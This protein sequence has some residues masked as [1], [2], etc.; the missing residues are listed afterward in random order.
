M[1]HLHPS[2]LRRRLAAAATVAS[3]ASLSGCSL[4]SYSP[5]LEL[6]KATGTAASFMAA[7]VPVKAIDTVHHG[8]TRIDSVC[9]AFN[10]GVALQGFLPAIQTA[11]QRQQVN[12][13][14]FESDTP[15]PLCRVWLHYMASVEWGTPPWGNSL[16]PYVARATLTLKSPQGLVL[17]SSNFEPGGVVEMGKWASTSDKVDAVV[18]ALLSRSD[19]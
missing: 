17:A 2:A 14:V 19:S 6:I 15:T 4:F 9:I 16:R 10:P 8:A 18:T 7:G 13:R 5:S 11:L 12:S 1:A 3:L